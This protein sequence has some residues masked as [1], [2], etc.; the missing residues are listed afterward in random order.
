[1]NKFILQKI[2]ENVVC[3]HVRVCA[4]K[5]AGCPIPYRIGMHIILG[6]IGRK[7]DLKNVFIGLLS[8]RDMTGLIQFLNSWVCITPQF[9]IKWDWAVCGNGKLF[10]VLACCV[11][12]VIVLNLCIRSTYYGHCA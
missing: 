5:A 9:R 10:L 4:R 8:K 12:Q 2:F 1:M 6:G 7:R 3:V 11:N